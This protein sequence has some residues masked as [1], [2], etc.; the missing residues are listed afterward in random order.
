MAKTNDF[1]SQYG[2]NGIFVI[3]LF[4]AICLTYL[5]W[6]I[7]NKV[8]SRLIRNKHF[9]F[10]V[11]LESL[12]KPLIVFVWISILLIYLN[13]SPYLSHKLF[14]D[15]LD[16]PIHKLRSVNEILF[17]GWF[18]MRFIKPFE[19]L[20]IQGLVIDRNLDKTTIQAISKLMKVFAITIMALFMLPI[21]GIPIS[22]ILA[23]SGGSA[24]VIGIGA[25]QI[26]ANYW[27]GIIIHSDR[28]F[29]VGD[30]VYSPDK[31][32]EGRVEYINWRST[33]I[34]M[35]DKR[36]MYVPNSLF[37]SIIVV[38][39]SR[40]SNWRIKQ[41]I[42]IRYQDV[43]L[44]EKIVLE[45]ID[46]LYNHTEIDNKENIYACLEKVNIYSLDIDVC[47][48]TK[49]IDKAVFR[50]VQ[51]NVILEIINIISQ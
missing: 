40:I 21:L 46:M 34:R 1:I 43:S 15:N 18:F 31:N 51:Q 17:I 44:L 14:G 39:S 3:I 37:V 24:I 28:N 49:T 42:P 16:L 20:L 9:V 27:G 8:S 47:A 48:Y 5:F 22:G 45:I 10:H 12:Y 19:N 29:S 32:I 38:N 13:N 11:L 6:F 23:L 26:I 2:S 25:Q 41:T 4:S 33:Q 30:F 50:S 35:P 36:V 7:Y